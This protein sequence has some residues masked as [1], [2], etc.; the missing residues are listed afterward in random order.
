MKRTIF[1]SVLSVGLLTSGLALAQ[2]STMASPG[3][4]SMSGKCSPGDPK[5]AGLDKAKTGG[6]TNSGSMSDSGCA[7]TTMSSGTADEPNGGGARPSGGMGVAGAGGNSS[8][9]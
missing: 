4:T 6:M 7:S 2:T 3:A 9:K 5:E 1:Y 8:G